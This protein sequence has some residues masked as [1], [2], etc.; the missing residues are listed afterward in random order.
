MGRKFNFICATEEVCFSCVTKEWAE[1]LER[2]PEGPDYGMSL[3][4]TFQQGK[5]T[6]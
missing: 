6:T 2:I 1:N 5:K 3:R 4:D